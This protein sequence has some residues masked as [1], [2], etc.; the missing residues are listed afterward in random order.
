MQAKIEQRKFQLAHQK[1]ASVEV[2]RGQHALKQLI[3]QWRVGIDMAR[4]QIQRLPI[5]R[6]ILHELAGQLHRIPLHAINAADGGQGDPGQQ[7]MQPVA[8]LVEQ[9][10]HI[11]VAEQCRSAGG[12][13][14]KVAS[15]E[16]HRPLHLRAIVKAR[17]TH[18][19]PGS[20]A[21]AIARIQIQIRAGKHVAFGIQQVD[22]THI[23]MPH[24]DTLVR[25]DG[26]PVQLVGQRKQPVDDGR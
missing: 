15:D 22:I 13:W 17:T 25:H 1:Q 20:S 6:K 7:V 11:V 21:L 24:V 16:R 19:H 26:N 18:I 9:R 5:P 14:R 12:R 2:A 8:K 3:G 23:R 10:L 4:K